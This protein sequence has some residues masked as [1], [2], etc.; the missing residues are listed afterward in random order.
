M[1]KEYIKRHYFINF[2]TSSVSIVENPLILFIYFYFILFSLSRCP[3]LNHLEYYTTLQNFNTFSNKL[4][5]FSVIFHIKDT[6]RTK[7]SKMPINYWI[8][9]EHVS[10]LAKSLSIEL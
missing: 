5:K 6:I 4:S 8:L 7:E 1:I 3:T 2:F 9:I 10:R